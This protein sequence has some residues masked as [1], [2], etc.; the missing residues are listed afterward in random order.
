MQG[1]G[2]KVGPHG[3]FGSCSITVHF[4]VLCIFSCFPTLFLHWLFHRIP[5]ST[6]PHEHT[7]T[8]YRQQQIQN[9]QHL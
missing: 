7:Q 5:A 3:A 9:K 2:Y 4:P 1:R 6:C 8:N